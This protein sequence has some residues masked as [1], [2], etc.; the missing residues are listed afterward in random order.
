MF[1]GVKSG[2]CSK[3]ISR[4]IQIE[5]GYFFSLVFAFGINHTCVELEQEPGAIHQRIMR[6]LSSFAASL[7]I[8][9]IFSS[10]S[11]SLTSGA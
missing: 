5:N 1:K 2:R 9:S 3:F 4:D 10:I 7:N 8:G 6:E 11:S